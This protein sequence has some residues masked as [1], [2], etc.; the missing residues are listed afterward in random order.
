MSHLVPKLKVACF[1]L[2][3]FL[4]PLLLW[5][6]FFPSLEYVANNI[7]LEPTAL[8][9]HCQRS[10]KVSRKQCFKNWTRPTG[11][12]S[13]RVR[14]FGRDGDRTEV[15]PLEPAVQL[16]NRMNLPVQFI[17]IFFKTTSF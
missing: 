5:F 15:G 3:V 11:H 13:G 2:F 1:G 10:F 16:V 9:C 17:L 4:H 7:S 8:N 6:I 12:R 14:S